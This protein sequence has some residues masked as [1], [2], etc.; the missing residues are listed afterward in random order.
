MFIK[1]LYLCIPYYSMVLP[2]RGR[3]RPPLPVAELITTSHG[4][5]NISSW[6]RLWLHYYSKFT[7]N[8]VDVINIDYSWAFIHA[9]I[10]TFNKESVM[11]YLRR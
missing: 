11:D 2:G 4:V 3:G 5:P 9:V 7:K 10:E 6:L 1:V 8:P